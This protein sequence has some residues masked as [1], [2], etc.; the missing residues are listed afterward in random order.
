MEKREL[1]E[2]HGPILKQ[3]AKETSAPTVPAVN[4]NSSSEPQPAPEERRVSFDIGDS[5]DGE[6]KERRVAF[7]I[8]DSDDPV[9]Y[10]NENSGKFAK[11]QLVMLLKLLCGIH[12]FMN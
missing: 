5:D 10:S 3:T 11:K 7:N 6:N 4:Q 1:G 2:A 8:G 9:D 12:S